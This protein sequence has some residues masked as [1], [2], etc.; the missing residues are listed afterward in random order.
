MECLS[1]STDF[2]TNNPRKTAN[3]LFVSLTLLFD[4]GP[5]LHAKAADHTE[6]KALHW[7]DLSTT[8]A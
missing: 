4:E 8:G 5:H 1:E 6:Q 3:E 2:P 7:S